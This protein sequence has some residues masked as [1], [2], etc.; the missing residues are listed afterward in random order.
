MDQFTGPVCEQLSRTF[1]PRTSSTRFARRL[2][3][4]DRLN[5]AVPLKHLKRRA[6]AHR[7]RPKRRIHRW[8]AVPQLRA[9]AL[10]ITAL[11][12]RCLRDCSRGGAGPKRTQH[13]CALVY[14]WRHAS[15]HDVALTSIP[16]ARSVPHGALLGK[17]RPNV[18]GHGPERCAR[19]L[20]QLRPA[21][22]VLLTAMRCSSFLHQ[23]ANGR[24]RHTNLQHYLRNVDNAR[25]VASRAALT[26]LARSHPANAKDHESRC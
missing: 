11:I 14:R 22:L 23:N 2:A 26:F 24:I 19:H 12:Q 5:A 8:P 21:D 20:A 1:G 17:I 9:M 3:Y 15:R 16:M 25:S 6:W 10:I 7:G 4:A 18:A 13:P